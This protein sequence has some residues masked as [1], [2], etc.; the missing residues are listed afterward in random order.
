MHAIFL[1]FEMLIFVLIYEDNRNIPVTLLPCVRMHETAGC[2][3][4]LSLRN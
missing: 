2:C 4:R 1:P 3:A